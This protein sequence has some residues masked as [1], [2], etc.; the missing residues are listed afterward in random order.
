[1]FTMTRIL[2][3]ALLLAL[4]AFSIVVGAIACKRPAAVCEGSSH[5][6]SPVG[7]NECAAAPGLSSQEDCEV[8]QG[9]LVP[10]MPMPVHHQPSA[11][12][13]PT[14]APPRPQAA[15]AGTT[16]LHRRPRGQVIYVT[17]EAESK[18]E[19]SPGN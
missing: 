7:P 14:L 2:Q 16:V 8:R 11:S 18:G 19:E 15:L 6:S 10:A 17:V 3:G 9:P 4:L 1:M 13:V 5:A 12:Q